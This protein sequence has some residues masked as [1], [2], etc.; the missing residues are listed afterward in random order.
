[1]RSSTTSCLR[2]A[3]LGECMFIGELLGLEDDYN[4][5]AEEV[6]TSHRVRILSE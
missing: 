2:H 6:C 4:Q 5:G 1:M 3:L